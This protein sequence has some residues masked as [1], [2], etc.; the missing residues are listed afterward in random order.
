MVS[1][2]L[3]FQ[4]YLRKESYVNQKAASKHLI[5]RWCDLCKSNKHDRR[6]TNITTGW[7]TKQKWINTSF[8]ALFWL[9][10]IKDRLVIFRLIHK[11]LSKIHNKTHALTQKH[12][13]GLYKWMMIF[14]CYS[15]EIY[16]GF[17]L[18]LLDKCIR[19][20]KDDHT[21]HDHI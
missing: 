4:K 18:I 12:C 16:F 9:F 20:S 7:N 10:L 5:N 3:L 14:P 2:E 11:P 8:Q 21:N 17:I 15:I 19:C 1:I 6:S 13:T